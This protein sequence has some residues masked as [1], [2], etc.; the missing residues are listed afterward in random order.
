MRSLLTAIAA[1]VL[2]LLGVHGACHSAV[3]ARASSRA[4]VWELLV[5]EHADCTYCEVFRRDVLPFYRQAVPGNAVPLRFV[6]LVTT[7]PGAFSLKAR[8]EA[9]PTA[10]L[11]KDG[12]EVGR[13]V[14]Y[15]GR[16]TFFRLLTHMLTRMQ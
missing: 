9:V 16:D 15:R 6:D 3:D 13:I 1:S 11:M 7:A 5:F 4:P 12:D 10:V 8:I 14:G 2:L